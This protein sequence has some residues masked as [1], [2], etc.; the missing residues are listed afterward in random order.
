MLHTLTASSPQS[1]SIVDAEHHSE[2]TSG[3][4]SQTGGRAIL[5]QAILCIGSFLVYLL[6]NRPEVLLVSRL[7]MI[8]WYPAVG[9]GF[10]LMLAIS[11]R[12][13]PLFAVAGAAAGMLFYRQTFFSW[14]TLV[15]IPVESALYAVA[16]HLLRGPQK[17]DSS[18]RQRRDV[19]RYVLITFVTAI[20]AALTGAMCLWADHTIEGNQLWS[21]GLSWYFSDIIGLLSVA[22]F[23]LIH[24][25][26]WVCKRTFSSGS[27]TTWRSSE[28][29]REVLGIAPLRILEFAGQAAAFV[30]LFWIMFGG[31]APRQLFYLAF[32]PVIWIAM[33]QGIGGA[34]IGLLA[35]NFGIVASIR[36]MSV[37]GEVVTKLSLLMLATSATG[38]IVGSAVSERR[39]I[40]NELRERTIFLNSLIE[41][42]PFGIVVLDRRAKIQLYNQAFADLFLYSPREIIGQD[43]KQLIVPEDL[44]SEYKRFV[45]Q[46]ASGDPIHRTVRRVRKDGEVVDVETHAL[47]LVQDGQV[48]GG[49]VIY[50]DISEQ[51][52]ASVAAKEHADA[53]GHWVA[54]LELRTM[55]ITLLNEMGSLLQCA[56]S[57]EEAFAVIGQSAKQL[58][59]GARSGAL[60]VHKSSQHTLEVAATWG[61]SCA[62][63]AVFAPD[64]CWSL[65]TGQPHWSESPTQSVVCAHVDNSF[66]ANYLCVPMV[67]HGETLGVL[68]LRCNPDHSADAE[69]DQKSRESVKRLAALAAGQI[70]LSLA[71]LHLRETL[72][73]Q[74]IRDPLTGLFNR[75]FMQESLNK[76]LQRSRRKQ[77][78]LAII[79][80]DLDHFKH[81]NDAFGHDAGDSV[82]KSMADIFRAHFRTDDVICRYG[83]EE[84][85]V[86]LP[87]STIEDAARRAEA[88]R[89]ATRDLKVVY[90]GTSL[91]PVTLSIG[92]AG[93]P[94]HAQDAQELLDRA[95][96]CLY[97][98][99]AHGRDRVTVA[100]APE[101]IGNRG[102][103]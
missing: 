20:L 26:P 89:L 36:F 2:T 75:R 48:E 38:L 30:L 58:F 46:I 11:P 54:E 53:L 87:E 70:A 103:V 91:G 68:H 77:R 73:D 67:A 21:S 18:L 19:M 24:V 8:V 6:L 63:G 90:R 4:R 82:L 98:S 72:R 57:S 97:Q 62:L 35:L 74:S 61:G 76:E 99:K 44:H 42:S 31:P 51:V 7:G 10:A 65:R 23:L 17:I 84:F 40:A 69:A 37:S 59:L 16:A 39:R 28:G 85:A 81:F 5:S 45:G 86:I 52:R 92:I 95:D 14:G 43:L 100:G 15:G 9:L 32:L 78:P 41:N 64:D 27:D 47:P 60:F 33:R 34:V 88:L 49:Y 3:D 80:L 102:V 55:Q 25:L 96:K 93:F 29:A 101:L 13:M 66:S 1:A 79:F 22:P 94:D 56:K 83:G 50:K 12:Y 71:N